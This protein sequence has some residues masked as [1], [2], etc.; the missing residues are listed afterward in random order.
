MTRQSY[1]RFKG[2]PLAWPVMLVLVMAGATDPTRD[3][4]V[5]SSQRQSATAAKALVGH[6]DQ[7]DG[8]TTRGTLRDATV[9]TFR[10][11]AVGSDGSPKPDAQQAIHQQRHAHLPVTRSRGEASHL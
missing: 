9:N 5:T 11:R 4:A 6:K 3:I 8:A 2:C 7:I 1:R 10:R